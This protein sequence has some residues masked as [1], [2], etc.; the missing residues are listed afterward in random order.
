VNSRKI[1]PVV[2][3]VPPR[4]PWPWQKE[5]RDKMRGRKVFALLMAMRTGKTKTLL[6]DYGELEAEG[7]CVNLMVTAPGG[8]YETWR[9]AAEEELSSG[10]L[11]RMTIHVWTSGNGVGERRRRRAF[12][13]ARGPRL[14]VMNIEALS[15]V[16]EARQ[17]AVDFLSSAVSMLAV[18]E[19]TTIKNSGARRSKFVIKSLGPLAAYRR[20]LSGL[21]SPRSPLDVYAQ[22]A[23]LD[24]R[25]IGHR[26]EWTFKMRYAI[27]VR[28]QFGGRSFLVVTGYQNVE[29]LQKLIEPYSYRKLLEDCYELPE[30]M[31]SIR[32]VDMTPEQRRLYK[33]LKEFATTQIAS[34][35]HVTATIVIVQMLRLHQIL[36]GH[37]V[38]EEGVEHS[39]PE[40]KTRALLDLLEEYD[41]KAIIWCSYDA[42][43]LKVSAALDKEYGKGS[44]ARFWGGNRREREAEERRFKGDPACRFMAATPAAG[45]KGRMWAVANLVIY[46]SSTN[47]LEHR[48]QSEER[49]QA[50]NKKDHVSY[51]DLICRGTVEEKFLHALR[52]KINLSS[53]ITGDS[54]REWVV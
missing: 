41:G 18:D 12:M 38:D 40:N 26:S 28:R 9:T 43:I 31:Y 23:F 50:V 49:P 42:D 6:D 21:P 34:E 44:C 13:E 25:I 48:S 19:S 2:K 22:F 3:Y 4:A 46:Y 20:I 11:S 15:S 14:L 17:M 53:M 32:Y 8:V 1:R 45:G 52:Q 39:V 36:C 35:K 54:W 30:K 27:Q 47:D 7:L 16:E 51:V 10:L 33:E 37:V 24:W 5:A 29:E